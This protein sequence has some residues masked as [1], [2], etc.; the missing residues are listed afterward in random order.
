M[1]A[2]LTGEFSEIC[3]VPQLMTEVSKL[4]DMEIT[5]V[6]DMQCGLPQTGPDFT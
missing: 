4:T 6:F 5:P 1:L 2:D 3:T